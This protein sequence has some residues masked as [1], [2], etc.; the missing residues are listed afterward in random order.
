MTHFS[1]LAAEVDLPEWVALL[2][3][4]VW[5]KRWRPSNYFVDAV[6]AAEAVELFQMS[7]SKVDAAMSPIAGVPFLKLYQ[8]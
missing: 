8:K 7:A 6:E 1:D 4:E 3:K 5:R 2:N